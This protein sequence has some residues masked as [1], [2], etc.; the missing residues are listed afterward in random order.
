MTSQAQTFK[1][2]LVAKKKKFF[3]ISQKWKTFLF[4]KHLFFKLDIV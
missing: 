2:Q 3:L 1:L 4:Y